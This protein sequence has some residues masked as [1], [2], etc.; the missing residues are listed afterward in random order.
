MADKITLNIVA[1]DRT[2][3]KGLVE[4]VYAPGFLGEFGILD[5]HSPYFCELQPGVVR[6]KA[7]GA[8]RTAAVAE[9]F[10]AIS[11]NTVTLLVEAA[12]YPEEIDAA[13]AES[14]K[15]RAEN[16]LKGLNLF[17]PEYKFWE[18]RRK[19]ALVRLLLAA[20]GTKA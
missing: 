16:K 2:L 20:Q 1:P 5:G 6:F 14:Y 3:F 12:E 13:K 19:R 4:D 15:V 8:H 11:N 10:A 17:D 9:G 18:L 7:N